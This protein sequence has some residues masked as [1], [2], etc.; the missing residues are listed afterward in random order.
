MCWCGLIGWS[1]HSCRFKQSAERSCGQL[2]EACTQPQASDY[3]S[4][5]LLNSTQ[6]STDSSFRHFVAR[7]SISNCKCITSTTST[8]GHLDD[9]NIFS[10]DIC[11]WTNNSCN[12]Y[13]CSIIISSSICGG[14]SIYNNDSSTIYTKSS[15]SSSMSICVGV[16]VQV[17]MSVRGGACETIHTCLVASL[18][19]DPQRGAVTE[20]VHRDPDAENSSVTGPHPARVLS[21]GE[22]RPSPPKSHLQQ[23]WCP[24]WLHVR[25]QSNSWCSVF[26]CSSCREFTTCRSFTSGLCVPTFTS[27]H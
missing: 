1:E 26:R 5:K 21:E 8:S 25:D 18:T 15:I 24:F 19:S 13:N 6:K 16:S 10:K 12:N 23:Q 7:R 22:Y 4:W 9:D 14:N 11:W 20:R 2:R 17:V 27:E 3:C